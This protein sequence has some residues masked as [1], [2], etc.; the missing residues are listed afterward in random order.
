MGISP[1]FNNMLWNIH[2]IFIRDSL[3]SLWSLWQG[4]ARQGGLRRD[5]ADGHFRK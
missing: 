4:T 3:S 5:I 2:L 1:I